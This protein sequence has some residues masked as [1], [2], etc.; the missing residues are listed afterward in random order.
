MTRVEKRLGSPERMLG[1][2][3]A[4]L[5]AA[6][7]V[8]CIHVVP[9]T[10]YPLLQVG[11]NQ[12]A[13]FAV[14]F[15]FALSG[16]FL[17]IRWHR[18]QGSHL[19]LVR[20]TVFRQSTLL[21]AW[22]AI[23]LIPFGTLFD[24]SAAPQVIPQAPLLFALSGTE[25][26]LWFLPSLLLCTAIAFLAMTLA[27]RAATNVLLVFGAVLY[28]FG[29]L[30]KAYAATPIGIV[31]LLDTRNGPFFGMLPFAIGIYF[32]TRGIPDKS[33]AVGLKLFLGGTAL[34]VL[35]ISVLYFGYGV[36]FTRHDFVFGTLLTGTGFMLLALAVRP[37]TSWDVV[38]QMG[39][40]ALGI[41][42]VHVAVLR[43]LRAFAFDAYGVAWDFFQL[44]FIFFAS[45]LISMGL[46]RVQLFKR[47][48]M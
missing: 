13:R 33:V 12:G 32:G 45:L 10:G 30:G 46:A 17:A 28:L 35:E 1:V 2:D 8:I 42:L 6:F 22:F 19:A 31:T 5:I 14:P 3:A 15:F 39:K 9:F 4:R 18:E 48:V 34:Q 41:Y 7:A 40:Y 44:G 25:I 37:A 11:V 21:V 23:Y 20:K 16:Y 26:H 29:V 38:G 36:W 27:G 43:V 47:F 24:P